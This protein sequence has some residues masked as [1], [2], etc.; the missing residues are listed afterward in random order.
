M[1]SLAKLCS[2]H[3][4]STI[5]P[6][7]F[8][9]LLQTSVV[10]SITAFNAGVLCQ[11]VGCCNRT[12][13]IHYYVQQIIPISIAVGYAVLVNSGVKPWYASSDAQKLLAEAFESSGHVL[14]QSYTALVQ[15]R[16]LGLCLGTASL[17][18]PACVGITCMSKGFSISANPLV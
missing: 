10:L 13:T 1:H 18:C 6:A 17:G 9:V 3:Q 11:F 4:C 12:G 14:E 15:V 16:A 2:L 7:T 8:C 5:I